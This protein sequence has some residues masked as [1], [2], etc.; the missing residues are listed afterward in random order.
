MRWIPTDPTLFLMWPAL[1]SDCILWEKGSAQV[2][3][4]A[5]NRKIIWRL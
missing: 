4:Y 5:G 1:Q 2:W 3:A